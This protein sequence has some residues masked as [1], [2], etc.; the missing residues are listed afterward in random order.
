MWS[1]MFNACLLEVLQFF[2]FNNYIF[3]YWQGAFCFQQSLFL[4]MKDHAGKYKAQWVAKFDIVSASR[5]LL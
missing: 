2:L 5:G 4:D 1:H 3:P